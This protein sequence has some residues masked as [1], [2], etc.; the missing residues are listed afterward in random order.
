ML[1]SL[2]RQ[3]AQLITSGGQLILLL[4]GFHFQSR[5]A[6]LWILGSMAV[7]SLFAWF[8]ALRRSRLIR[9]TPTSRIASAA[10]GYVELL[11]QARAEGAPILGKCS[12]LPCLWYRYQVERKNHKN[13]W[14]TVD[15]GESSTPFRLEDGSGNCVIDPRGGEIIARHKDTWQ[16]GDERYTEWKLLEL[17][18]VYVLGEFKTIGGSNNPITHDE[19]VKQ[20][21]YEWK[22][23]NANL[24]Q[25]FDLNGNGLLDMD[26][27]L[28]ARQAAKREARKRLNEA[29][30]EGD[31]H[32]MLKPRDGR[33]FLIS[34]VPPEKLA[35]RYALWTWLHLLIF[36]GALGSIAWM[37][38][39]S[40]Q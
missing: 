19:L 7:I 8:S 16:A 34:N 17:D 6:W 11:G 23:D 39:Q 37:L 1:A 32:F 12:L 31:T 30:A 5:T 25:R 10:Q 15:G 3:Y 20:V 40:A 28:L 35:R 24:L 29:R 2:R 27:W 14:R 26:E 36:F 38:Q 21:L 22:L 9:S 4:A 13:E 18:E 33:L